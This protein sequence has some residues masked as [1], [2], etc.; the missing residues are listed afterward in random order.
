MAQPMTTGFMGPA[1]EQGMPVMHAPQG[2]VETERQ[3]I[4]LEAWR[5]LSDRGW[6][7]ASVVNLHPFQLYPTGVLYKELKIQGV[8]RVRDAW[9]AAPKLTLSNGVKLPYFKHVFNMP[10]IT[11]APRVQGSELSPEVNSGIHTTLPRHFAADILQQNNTPYTRG[12]VFAYEGDHEPFTNPKTVDVEMERCEKA[13]ANAITYYNQLLQEANNFHASG[14]SILIRELGKSKYHRWAVTYLRLLGQLSK[15]P[16]WFNEEV[17]SG[18]AVSK[19][20][21]SCGQEV[22]AGALRCTNGSCTY[23]FEPYLAYKEGVFDETSPGGVL[24]LRRCTKEQLEE[25]GL[26]PEISPRDEHHLRKE[27][28]TKEPKGN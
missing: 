18:P 24:A 22:K 6:Q 4:Y 16:V 19:E 8:P 7:A 13:H 20:C 15:D 5:D 28:K 14:N 3:N 25:L 10:D 2:A 26:Y 27:R 9:D 23:I 1:S 11:I 17:K 12:G 21:K